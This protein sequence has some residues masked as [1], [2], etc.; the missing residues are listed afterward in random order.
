MLRRHGRAQRGWCLVLGTCERPA[1]HAGAHDDEPAREPAEQLSHEARIL[2]D[3][4]ELASHRLGVLAPD[5][6][7]HRATGDPVSPEDPGSL[8]D[9]ASTLDYAGREAQ[10]LAQSLRD[11][12]ASAQ[13]ATE[14][15]ATTRL[16]IDVASCGPDLGP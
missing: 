11:L 6:D 3:L 2:A 8:R 14:D 1:G 15:M 10:R 13:I 9:V 7:Q 4:S 5:F 16:G 12:A